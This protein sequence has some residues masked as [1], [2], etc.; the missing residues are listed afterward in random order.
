MQIHKLSK[1][2]VIMLLSIIV[3]SLLPGVATVW[4]EAEMISDSSSTAPA[5]IP[6]AQQEESDRRPPSFL[7]DTIIRYGN[8]AGD[9][10][11]QSDGSGVET[12]PGAA[13]VHT[14]QLGSGSEAKDWFFSFAGGYLTNDSFAESGLNKE[15]CLIAPVYLIPGTTITGFRSYVRDNSTTLDIPIFLDRTDSFGGW[16]E[17]AAVQSAGSS[18][19][20]QTLID[21]SITSEGSANVVALDFN[22][23]VSLCLP[24][25]S[26]FSILVYGAQVSYTFNSAPGLRSVYLPV[27]FRSDPSLSSVFITNLSGGPLT[28]T[29]QNTPQ[30]NITCTVPNGARNYFC[31]KPFTANTYNWTAQLICGPLG[32]KSK[33]FTPGPVYPT[34]F[35]CD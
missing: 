8:E 16:T 27:I 23:H 11:V 29:V 13:F 10:S 17:L 1:T 25:G 22:Y 26:D 33:N 31:D 7:G 6:P 34:P 28:Y 14:N 20:I 12:V 21:P 3:A 18:A 9:I 4:A 2:W 19:A 30:G 5:L 35:R 15:V 24:A 32:P